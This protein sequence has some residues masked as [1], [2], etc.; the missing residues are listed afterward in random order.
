[1][2]PLAALP[3]QT[4][5]LDTRIRHRLLHGIRARIFWAVAGLVIILASALTAAAVYQRTISLQQQLTEHGLSLARGLARASELGVLTHNKDF[6]APVMEGAVGEPDIIAVVVLDADAAVIRQV[7]ATDA[8]SRLPPSLPDTV[9]Q[10]I[11]REFAP[12]WHEV[13]LANELAYQFWAPVVTIKALENEALLLDDAPATSSA[14][15]RTL[16]GYVT[17]TL[18][19]KRIHAKMQE[20]ITAGLMILALFLPFSLVIAYLLASGVTRPLAKLVQVAQAVAQGDL[21]QRIDVHGDDEVAQLATSF[22]GMIAEVR[23]RDQALRAAHDGL[24]RR[25]A[26]RT[27]ELA[28]N[29]A[30]LERRNRDLDQF[31]YVAAHDLKTPLR[32][33]SNL[34]S[35]IAE[36]VGALLSTDGRAQMQLLQ[37]RVRRAENLIDALREYT[38]AGRSSAVA[39]YVNSHA[40][41]EKVIKELAV[42]PGFT[43]TVA[44]DMPHLEVVPEV[45]EKIFAQLIGNAIRF[46]HRSEGQINVTS[47][48]NGEQWAFTV[49]D[50]GPGIAPQFHGK[51]FEIFQTLHAKDALE[52]TGV[53]LPLVKKIIEEHGGEISLVSEEGAGATFRFTWPKGR[54]S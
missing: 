34:A 18:S 45:L 32:G 17:L 13:T 22:N 46:H 8:P 21:T 37:A 48:N 12:V 9:R 11:G 38:R 29:N 19:L 7:T 39:E 50:D 6:L 41:V 42:P 15:R 26:E 20:V 25:V 51:V 53:G 31:A 5:P 24:E 2:P 35:W 14:D 28:R 47:T 49:R 30:A 16:I 1:M 4:V 33:I 54:A 27:V 40:L 36:D 3:A 10:Q 52:T 43:V 23:N 44:T